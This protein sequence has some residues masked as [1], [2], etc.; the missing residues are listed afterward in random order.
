MVS[1]NLTESPHP[2]ERVEDYLAPIPSWQRWACA[3]LSGVVVLGLMWGAWLL[4][5]LVSVPD[6]L[7]GDG[8]PSVWV[9]IIALL[10]SLCP[11]SAAAAAVVLTYRVTQPGG[12][13]DSSGSL[14]G[15][16]LLVLGA[17]G[18]VAYACWF[19]VSVE[20]G[21]EA[22]ALQLAL[23]VPAWATVSAYTWQQVAR[24]RG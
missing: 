17:G 4:V 7:A 9:Q 23:V 16:L 20:F 5:A 12:R 15:D 21:V 18:I 3:G 8:G 10:V 13:W 11:F 6:M 1:G 14:L 2:T 22:G 19:I 24:R